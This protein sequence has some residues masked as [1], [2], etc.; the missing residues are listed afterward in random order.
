MQVPQNNTYLSEQVPL[1]KG[2]LTCRAE[3]I[4][5][6]IV[7]GVG[8]RPFIKRTALRFGLYGFVEN[9]EYG[10]RIIAVGLKDKILEFF[11]DLLKNSP[12]VAKI[13]ES[14]ITYKDEITFLEKDFHIEISKK[15]GE[16]S[17]LIPPDIASCDICLKEVDNPNNRHYNYPF[18]NC[19]NCGPRF[20]IIKSIPYD[21]KNTTMKDFEMCSACK[22]EYSTIEDRRFHA[23]PTACPEC[24]PELSLIRLENNNSTVI[25]YKQDALEKTIQLLKSG[26][27]VAIK[28]L[29]GYHLA[30]DALNISTVN[31]LRKLKHRPF[32]PFAL[33]A[34]SIKTIEKYCYVNLSEKKMLTGQQKPIVLLKKKSYNSLLHIAPYIFNIG[35]MLTY[36]PLHHIIMKNFKVLVMTSGNVSDEALEKEDESALK[37][38]QPITKYFLTYNREI[39]N[40]VDDSII[41]FVD[42]Q[43]ILI[44]KARGF[45]PIPIKIDNFQNTPQI[46]TAGADMKGSFGLIKNNLFIGSQYLGDLGYASNIDFYKETLHYFENIFEIKPEIA[47]ADS[48]P[49]YFSTNFAENYARENNLTL[50]HIQH[51]LA[52]TYSVMAEHNLLETIGVSFDG[53]GFG[54]DGNIWGGEFFIVNGKNNKR[55]AHLKYQP[56]VSGEKMSKEPWRMALIYLY[57]SCPEEIDNFIGSGKFPQKEF[58]L[59]I[60]KHKQPNLYTSSIGRLFDAVASLLSVCHYN[61]YEGEAAMKLEAL[62]ISNLGEGPPNLIG[63]YSKKEYYNW[64]LI[65]RNFPWEID[66]SETIKEIVKDIQKKKSKNYISSRFH[67]TILDIIYQTCQKIRQKFGIDNVSFSG[68]V[69]Q[70][71]LLVDIIMK[72]F[73][74]SEFKIFFNE[75]VPPNDAGIALG[76]VYG[77][78]LCRSDTP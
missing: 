64:H 78:L 67:F 14:E 59:K 68:G 32:K 65:T 43:K 50:I 5:K 17:A 63:G 42:K 36:T 37:N 13:I 33:M 40:R 7:Q 18:T 54:D 44:R 70:N 41:K 20:S 69:F 11:D 61:S 16:I 76:Q 19:T 4:L 26:E 55:V 57:G 1:N 72:R 15:N 49:N 2:S 34:D 73:K 3:I 25:A 27:I 60:L 77:Y 12:Q 21:R 71:A 75:Q 74:N 51:H 30:C 28:G 9:R 38:L 22:Q 48:H 29:G 52:H 62:V 31:R 53:T 58:I 46:F 39:F 56:V 8:F 10:V 23:Q 45:I 66:V 35:F 47:I 6:G 24:G